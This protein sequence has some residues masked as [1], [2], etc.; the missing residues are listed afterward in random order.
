[1]SR[2]PWAAPPVVLLLI[3]YLRPL[4]RVGTKRKPGDPFPFRTVARVAGSDDPWR[5][6]DDAVVSV[7]TFDE[8][9]VGALQEAWETH[10]HLTGLS[11]NPQQQIQV[12]G[13]GAFT[14]QYCDPI[15]GPVEVEEDDAGFV[16][17]VSRFEV[18]VGYSLLP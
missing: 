2:N 1:M 16:H 4:G 15:L 13:L 6:W 5:G 9:D 12:D 8:T 14:V 18:G 7:H 3:N 10:R 17:Y 11:V